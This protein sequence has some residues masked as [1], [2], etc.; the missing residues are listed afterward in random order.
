MNPS[1]PPGP[2]RAFRRE[3]KLVLEIDEH[4]FCAD[5]FL[6]SES[7]ILDRDAFLA[8]ACDNLFR[9]LHDATVDEQTWWL[10]Y[11]QAIG[12]GA[13]DAGAGVRLGDG[14]EDRLPVD[15]PPELFPDEVTRELLGA[16]VKPVALS[17]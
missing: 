4:R 13:A 1:L 9:V 2:L 5:A 7:R 15:Q 11:C 3:G 10:R 14:G 8:F 12:H 17:A 16:H 6:Q